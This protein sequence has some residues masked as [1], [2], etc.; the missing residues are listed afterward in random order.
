MTCQYAFILPFILPLFMFSFFFEFER[1]KFLIPQESRFL[2]FHR[3]PNAGCVTATFCPLYSSVCPVSV[4]FFLHYFGLC[5]RKMRLVQFEKEGRL[6]VGVELKEGGDVVD[7][8]SV[9]SSIP[10]NMKDFL[11]D[12]DNAKTKAQRLGNIY[13][14]IR[15]NIYW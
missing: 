2:K 11:H 9:D 3:K 13:C 5:V 8:C 15:L 1:A 10:S 6:S 4:S 14:L 7:V 12:L